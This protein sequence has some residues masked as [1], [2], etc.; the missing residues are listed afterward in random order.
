MMDCVIEATTSSFWML[1][2][3]YMLPDYPSDIEMVSAIAVK[4]QV[5]KSLGRFSLEYP[6]IP[7]KH[8]SASFSTREY[9]RVT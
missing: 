2:S 4:K 9:P 3:S 8:P 7:L 5:L 1:L 6:I